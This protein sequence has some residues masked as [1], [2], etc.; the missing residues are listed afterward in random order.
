MASATMI[1]RR[2]PVKR[3]FYGAPSPDATDIVTAAARVFGMGNRAENYEGRSAREL[4][5]FPG[6]WSEGRERQ[7][8]FLPRFLNVS[9]AMPDLSNSPKPSETIL[10]NCFFVAAASGRFKP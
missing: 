7:P 4:W 2:V 10:S 3:D 1:L 6:A 8:V 9:S 5:S